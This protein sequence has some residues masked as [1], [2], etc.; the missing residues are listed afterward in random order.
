MNGFYL[1][2]KYMLF[3]LLIFSLFEKI[4]DLLISCFR[5]YK[6]CFDNVPAVL[7]FDFR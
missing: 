4:Q 5:I 7:K 1:K 3:F 2:L 6:F